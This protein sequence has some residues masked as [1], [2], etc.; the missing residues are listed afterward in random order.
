ME[1]L[2]GTVNGTLFRND[3]NGY[4]VVSLRVEGNLQTAVGIFPELTDGEQLVLEGEWTHHAQYGRQFKA[5]G[6]HVETPTSLDAIEH[7]LGSGLIRGVGPSTARLIV[8]AFGKDTL[9]VLSAH[10]ERLLEVPKIGKK[11]M[12][13]IYESFAAQQQSR[14][15]FLFLQRY[16][17]TP[18]LSSKINKFYRDQAERLIR[19][20]PYRLIDDI[21]GVGFLTADR[22]AQSLGVTAD[23]PF[24]LRAGIK[25]V[26][27]EAASSSG[28][29]YLPKEELISKSSAILGADEDLINPQLDLL[30]Q[31]HALRKTLLEGDSLISLAPYLQAEQEIAQRLMNLTQSYQQMFQAQIDDR[32]DAFE[33]HERIRFSPAQ[34]DAIGLAVNSGLSV[35]T[36]GPGTGKTTLINC[37]LFVLGE[38]T[39]TLLAAPTGRAAKR[40]SEATGR[41]AS[42]IHRLLQFGG[43]EGVFL[44]DDENPLNCNCVIVDEVSMVDVFL[45]R[46]LLQAI[47]PGTRLV[48]VGDAD[49]LPSVGPGN[50]LADILSCPRIPQARLN[51]I[52][53]Q[54]EQSMIVVNAHRINRGEDPVANGTDS[55]FFFEN[56]P[57]A[58]AAADSIIALCTTRL[59]K[60]LNETDSVRALQ[61]LSPTKKG[62]CGVACLNQMLQEALNPP[63]PRKRELQFRE[64]ILRE[65]DKVIQIKN[66]YQLAWMTPDGEEGMGVFNGD[67]GFVTRIDPE[68]KAVTVQFD[69]LRSVQYEYAQLEEIELAYCLSVHKSQGSE[70][71]AVIIPVVGGPRMLL[72]RNL[73]YTAVTRARRLVVLVG[74]Q[75]VVQMMVANNLE[76]R[77]YSLLGH[78]L[79]A[80]SGAEA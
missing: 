14:N 17:I 52:F 69:D 22:I 75:Q 13:Q 23:S 61:V 38:E 45:M 57:D 33:K 42:T 11:R 39:K 70:F 7:Y 34:R 9:E 73:L 29:T 55:D 24:R 60:Y 40:M 71:P 10:P 44:M 2:Q 1:T 78:W 41:D 48:L 54:A 56:K 32:I 28:H 26:L 67:I 80:E 50:V 65:G 58:E 53:R 46:S 47:A 59:P 51:E 25:H 27:R 30:C 8:E 66:N 76:R 19:E 77:R 79:K 68:E 18:A 36:G 62:V 72:T 21:D 74:R 6:F 64:L 43:E 63:S 49:Q 5:S 35:I 12:E 37:L 3:E 4:S 16:G 31:N 15:T 20:N